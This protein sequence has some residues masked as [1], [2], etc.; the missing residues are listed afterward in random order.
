MRTLPSLIITLL[1]MTAAHSIAESPWSTG[2][3]LHEVIGYDL[4]SH[5]TGQNLTDYQTNSVCLLLG[6]FRGFAESSA[7]AAHYNATALPFFLPESIT[8][9]EIERIVYKYL[10]DNPGKLDLT[11]D[12]LLVSALTKAFPNTVFTP[13]PGPARKMLP[14]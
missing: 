9:D 12:A 14:Q 1:C 3:S 8:N 2:H 6:Y 5:D 7:V 11:G 4:Q 13:P 10:A